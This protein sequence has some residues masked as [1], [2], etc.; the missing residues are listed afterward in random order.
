MS[1]IVTIDT[2]DLYNLAYPEEVNVLTHLNLSSSFSASHTNTSPSPNTTTIII[3]PTTTPS[4]TINSAPT[5]D[6]SS[7]PSFSSRNVWEDVVF[8]PYTDTQPQT[9]LAAASSGDIPYSPSNTDNANIIPYSPQVVNKS[10][11]HPPYFPTNISQL[12]ALASITHPNSPNTANALEP[13]ADKNMNDT[14]TSNIPPPP[15]QSPNSANPLIPSVEEE[16]LNDSTLEK[17][18]SRLADTSSI[19]SD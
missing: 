16:D 10:I 17:E 15:P 2:Q 18:M 9:P 8:D 5:P 13:S 19:H 14:L 7:L 11:T 6:T 3:N 1:Q 4:T 12:P